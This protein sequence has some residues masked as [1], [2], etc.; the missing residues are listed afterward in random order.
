MTAFANR[1]K[2][3]TATTG[4][5]AVTLGAAESGFQSFAA[6]GLLVGARVAYL[7][8]DGTAW[9][10]GSGVYQ[11]GPTMTRS[12]RQSSTGALLSLTGAAKVSV[13]VAQEELA[14]AFEFSNPAQWA[15][16]KPVF[17]TGA[18]ASVNHRASPA[19]NGTTTG[20]TPTNANVLLQQVANIYTSS[21]TIDAITGLGPNNNEFSFVEGFR[22]VARFGLTQVSTGYR[23]MMGAIKTPLGATEP[24]AKFDSFC[25][26][27]DSTDT[28]FHLMLNVS[29]VV[30]KVDLGVA[31]ALNIL[32]EARLWVESGVLFGSIRRADDGSAPVTAS[33][34]SGLFTLGEV[35][36]PSTLVGHNSTTGTPALILHW[37]GTSWRSS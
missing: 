33:I 37:C 7:I 6:G 23:L 3:A 9:E 2:V 5:G 25:I 4:T 36:G 1:V 26:G 17:Q 19:G 24:S 30:T 8:E 21:A 29:G 10:I 35:F 13:I 32:Y 20:H 34:S 27:K 11:A 15:W 14:R 12:L 22:F 31:P 16:F 28:N 18:I